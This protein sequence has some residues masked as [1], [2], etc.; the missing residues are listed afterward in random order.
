MLNHTRLPPPKLVADFF[1]SLI[2]IIKIMEKLNWDE[3]FLLLAT[4]YSARA[5]CDRSRVACVLV[6]DKRMLGAGYNGSVSG[7][8]SCDE[9]GHLIVDNHCLRTI[10]AERNAL[11]NSHGNLEGGTAYV[12]VTPCLDCVKALLQRGIKRIVY[13]GNY[14]NSKAR[15]HIKEFCDKKGVTLEQVSENPEYSL[16]LLAK[17]LKR[18]RGPG[19]LFKDLHDEK[20]W[21]QFL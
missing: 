6:K 3:F 17:A 19:G 12:T 14:A 8:E 7:L 9:V 13:L 18:L 21:R 2:A 5:S 1:I 4:M 15:E 16:S 10:H 11:D 20:H